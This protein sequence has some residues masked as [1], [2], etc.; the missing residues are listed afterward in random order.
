M[1]IELLVP[2]GIFLTGVVIA[3]VMSGNGIA[4]MEENL[5]KK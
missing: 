3:I 4:L 1:P 2:L 5:K